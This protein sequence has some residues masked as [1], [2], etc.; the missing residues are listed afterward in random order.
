MTL[1]ECIY[2]VERNSMCVFLLV[3]KGQREQHNV[4]PD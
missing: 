2:I 1:T 4:I 3:V